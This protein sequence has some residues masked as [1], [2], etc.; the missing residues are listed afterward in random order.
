MKEKVQYRIP[1][2]REMGSCSIVGTGSAVETARENALW[3]Y[4]RA[5]EHDGLPP[6][7][8]MPA[9]TVAVPVEYEA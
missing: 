6:V 9:G 1:P 5:R 3:H 4:N 2:T 7:R 8:S